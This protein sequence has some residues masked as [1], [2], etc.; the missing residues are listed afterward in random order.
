VLA[1]KGLAFDANQ[2]QPEIRFASQITLAEFQDAL[3]P[4]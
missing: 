1:K 3:E 4:Q 2:P